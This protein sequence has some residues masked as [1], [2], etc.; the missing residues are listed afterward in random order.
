[1]THNSIILPIIV[2]IISPPSPF[3]TQLPAK[4]SSDWMKGLATE[5]PQPTRLGEKGN[6]ERGHNMGMIM[7]K[8]EL[9]W[10]KQKTWNQEHYQWNHAHQYS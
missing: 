8:K 7:R 6:K 10:L 5:D 4:I 3:T 2:I 9:T 1:M